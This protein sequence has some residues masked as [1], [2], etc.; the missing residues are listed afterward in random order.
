MDQTAFDIE[1]FNR[2]TQNDRLALNTL[3]AQYYQ[4][5]CS[6]AFLYL[7]NRQ[8]AEE[9]VSDMFLN[10]WQRRHQLRIH[11]NLKSYLFISVRNSSHAVIKARRGQMVDVD[12]MLL[13]EIFPDNNTPEQCLVFWELEG[14]FK[15]AIDILPPRCKEIFLLKWNGL[16]YRA[17]SEVLSISEKTV[18]NQ[19]VNATSK[20]RES[21]RQ[22]HICE[23][24]DHLA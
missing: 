1:L 14:Y 7:R 4:K 2:I 18:E 12:S 16:S 17:I 21:L 15:I 19:L 20:I 24:H 10:L 23:F 22:H 8:D 3:F 13:D 11:K 5:L 9:V 6:Y